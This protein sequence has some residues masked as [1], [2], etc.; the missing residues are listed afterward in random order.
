MEI[1]AL[2]LFVLSSSGTPG[3]N[4][5]ML[6]TSGA[7]HGI[8]RSIPHVFGINLG[9]PFMVLAVGLGLMSLFSVIPFLYEIIKAIGIV[10]LLFLAYKIATLP[11]NIEANQTSQAKPLSFIQ[12]AGFQWVNP[13]AWVMVVSAIAAFSSGSGSEFYQILMIASAYFVFGLPCSFAWVSVGSALQ[14]VLASA[15]SLKWFNRFM[16]LLLVLSITPMISASLNIS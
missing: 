4:N 10:Y 11:T 8:R 6:L 7:N 3:P 9:F 14:G 5:V 13:K 1:L 15:N 16:A 12:A 2:A